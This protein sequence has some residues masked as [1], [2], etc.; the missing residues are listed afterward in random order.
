MT[1]R[2]MVVGLFAAI[3]T[4]NIPTGTNL[5]QTTGYGAVGRGGASYVSTTNTGGTLYRTQSANGRWFDLVSN[6]P[7]VE[8]FGAVGDGATDDSAAFTG[9]MAFLD[10]HGGGM[11][12]VAAKRYVANFSIVGQNKALFCQGWTPSQSVNAQIVAHDG[13]TPAIQI[14]DGSTLTQGI[15][16]TGLAIHGL[17]TNKYGLKING[18]SYL[19]FDGL[20]AQGHTLQDLYITSSVGQSTSEIRFRHANIMSQGGASSV[21]LTVDAGG[22]YTTAVSFVQSKFSST[23]T[24]LGSLW[25]IKLTSVVVMMAG[26]CYV[27]AANGKGVRFENASTT[28]LVGDGTCIVDSDVSSDTLVSLSTDD[29]IAQLIPGFLIDGAVVMPAG[30]TTALGSV[31]L[32]P[33][34]S[35]IS[36]PTLLGNVYFG[37]GAT[38]DH[39]FDNDHHVS[40]SRSATDRFTISSSTGI[41]DL[42]AGAGFAQITNPS[43]KPALRLVDN[44]ALVSAYIYAG[45]GSPETVVAAPVGSLYLR[46]DGGAGTCL[47]VKESG[48]A[49][50]GWIAK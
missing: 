27:Q 24:G 1:V 25:A 2:P 28:R 16:I 34:G 42:E 6:F 13:N 21:G 30:T 19:N 26:N 14:G 11:G 39:D 46:T 12:F 41:I 37:Y 33:F 35:T 49:K 43:G 47:Y 18:A 5:I 32:F 4:L 9:L 31:P 20:T 50:T 48:T 22:S 3:A 29:N 38:H 44:S 7:T 40:M 15:S 8:M 23:S 45:A 17:G 10:V 36:S